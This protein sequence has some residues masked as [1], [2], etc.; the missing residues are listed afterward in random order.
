MTVVSWAKLFKASIFSDI[1]YPVGI[2]HEDEYIAHKLYL[3]TDKVLLLNHTYYMYRIREGSITTSNQ[4][5]IPKL[6]NPLSCFE[7]R[8]VDLL[9]ANKDVTE[10]LR[11][12]KIW[13]TKVK[14]EFEVNHLC[15]SNEY[16]R[17]VNKLSFLD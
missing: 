14:H 13:L 10:H 6:V 1:R 4:V 2:I 12:Y 11:N 9:L 8:I 17:I 16:L 5:T 15:D 7:E 3:K